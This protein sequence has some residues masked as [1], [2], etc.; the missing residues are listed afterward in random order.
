MTIN[1]TTLFTRLGKGFYLQSAVNTSRGT[2]IPPL[3]KAYQDQFDSASIDLKKAMNPAIQAATSYQSGA[4]SLMSSMSTSLKNTVI[5]TAIADTALPNSNLST[6]LTELIRQ[7]VASGDSVDKNTVAAS[8]S[9]I[10]GNGDG[11]LVVSAKRADGRYQEN[12]VAETLKVSCTSDTSPDTAGFTAV[13]A[14][15]VRDK[16]SSSWP[17]GSGASRGITATSADSTLLTN[18]NFNSST[19]V[20]NVPDSWIVSVGTPGTTLKMTSYEVQTLTVTGPPTAGTYSISWQAPSG[21]T[22]RTDPLAYNA[23]SAAIQAALRKF[24]GLSALTVSSTG[25]SPL[26]THTITF[27]G[28]AGNVNQ[29]TITNNTTGGTYTPATT[30]AG[31]ANAFIGRAVEFDSDGSQLTT[32]NQ[33]VTLSALSQYA[34]NLWMLADVVPAAG[35]ITVDLVDG[36]GGTVITD[37]QGTSSS[38]TITC[39]G[40]STSFAARNGVFRTPRVMPDK[41]YLRIRIST[42]VSSGTSIFFD[43]ASLVQMTELYTGGPSAAIF[44]GKSPFY[45]GD[46][47]VTPDYFTITTTNDR[48]GSFQE[49]FNRNFDM[50]SLGLLLPSASSGTISDSLI[51]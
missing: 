12:L 47:Q 37:E 48:A 45:A 1:L 20:D 2:T 46:T 50:A 7:M 51:A 21:K 11:V 24:P 31:S 30:T 38:F 19:V 9:S 13:G 44:S 33:P 29:I 41:V 15:A 32:L 5:Q 6:A 23:T 4:A 17:A 36:I 43:H 18:G 8:A 25:T 35:V 40:L 49:W 10:T 39:S 16:L 3:V 28:Q 14:T 26:Y 42:A 34:F 27:T 22:Y